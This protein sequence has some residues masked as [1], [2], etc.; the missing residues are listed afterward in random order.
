[1]IHFSLSNKRIGGLNPTPVGN[2]TNTHG[3]RW[4]QNLPNVNAVIQLPTFMAF[5][6]RCHPHPCV[7]LC[8]FIKN[9]PSEF[10]ILT[11]IYPPIELRC[12][13]AHP[14][15]E[16]QLRSNMSNP[17]TFHPFKW[18]WGTREKWMTPRTGRPTCPKRCA[19]ILLFEGCAF[20]C[21]IWP[22][23]KVQHRFSMLC[24]KVQLHLF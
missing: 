20:W 19:A 3:D 10:Q 21:T 4:T 18:Y 24:C 1:M 11:A 23:F 7:I 15:W 2:P 6:S 9:Y 5:C 13:T 17:S 14:R 12:A 16:A 22:V 8:M